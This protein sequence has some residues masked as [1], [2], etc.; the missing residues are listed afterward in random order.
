M[1]I[2]LAKYYTNMDWTI[3]RPGGLVTASATGAAKL[4][5]DPNSIGTI[6]RADVA[7]L[8]INSLSDE[9]TIR[10]VGVQGGG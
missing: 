9:N 7:A 5:D 6:R 10:K 8:V 2:V 1:L 3:I 4:L